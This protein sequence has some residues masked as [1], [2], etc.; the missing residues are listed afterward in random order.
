LQLQLSNQ[1]ERIVLRAKSHPQKQTTWSPRFY[2]LSYRPIV[3]TFLPDLSFEVV[4]IVINCPSVD[5]ILRLLA[6]TCRVF[7]YEATTL[8]ESM[9]LRNTGNSIA[10]VPMTIACFPLYSA[11][12][13][14]RVSEPFSYM[15]SDC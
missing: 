1:R 12:Y 4:V 6:T 13:S 10:C 14:A 9:R 8:R 3:V 15:A 5:T 2:C 7:V 11:V